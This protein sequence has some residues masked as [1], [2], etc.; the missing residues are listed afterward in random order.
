MATSPLSLVIFDATDTPSAAFA[1]ARARVTTP[2]G[3]AIG[4]PGLSPI[5]RAGTVLHRL[6]RAADASLAAT[7]WSE[8]LLWAATTSRA[9]GRPIRSLQLWGHGG[10]GSMTIGGTTLDTAALAADHPLAAPLDALRDA[11]DGPA[12]L[13]WMRCCSAFGH[14]VGQRF[15]EALAV[16]LGCRVAGHTHIIG[17]FQSGAHSLR[18]GEKARW[19]VDE[20][21]RKANGQAVGA[22]TSTWRAGNTVSCLALELPEDY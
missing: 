6:T 5:W 17:V 2:D 3:R 8:A 10:W 4:S 11:L 19:S 15:A 14:S 21:V 12:S 20:G 16:R 9:Q 22:L 18:P 7:S 1:R 13:F